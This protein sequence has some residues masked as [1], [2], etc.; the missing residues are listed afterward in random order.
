MIRTNVGGQQQST[1]HA[2]CFLSSSVLCL[3]IL[4]VF[5]LETVVL[6]IRFIIMSGQLSPRKGFSIGAR[7]PGKL[8]GDVTFE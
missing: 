1:V 6:G 2:I 7:E 3:Y 4:F 8:Q 5:S